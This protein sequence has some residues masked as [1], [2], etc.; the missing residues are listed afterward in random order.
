MIKL[1]DF[2]I[3]QVDINSYCDFSDLQRLDDELYQRLKA[4]TEVGHWK[5]I[6]PERC[7]SHG[8]IAPEINRQRNI[9]VG[10]EIDIWAFGIILY[11]VCVG[12]KPQQ[13]PKG[14]R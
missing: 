14:E 3:S 4:N 5:A 8:Y 11:Q 6:M 12:Y 2:G 13:V 9:V 10:P 7:G 1:A